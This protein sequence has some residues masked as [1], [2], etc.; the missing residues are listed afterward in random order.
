MKYRKTTSFLLVLALMPG[1]A[2]ANDSWLPKSPA[3]P[4]AGWQKIPDSLYIDLGD[5]P[6]SLSRLVNSPF[7]VDEPEVN[8][9]KSLICPP[10]YKKYLIRSF[11]LGTPTARVYKTPNGLV[12]SAGAFSD[13]RQPDKGAIAICL[14]A[15]PGVIEGTVSFLK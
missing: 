3:F 7:I 13:P 9:S 10:S 11:F 8:K 4:Q 14:M 1:A 15:D 2:C 6:E 12:V 5:D